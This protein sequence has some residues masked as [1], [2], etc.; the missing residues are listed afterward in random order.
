MYIHILKKLS[1]FVAFLFFRSKPYHDSDELLTM[2][3]RCST[4]NPLFNPR[5]N[6]CNNC[7]QVPD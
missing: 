5:G 7:H 1:K 3:Y 2:C 4:T 6:R